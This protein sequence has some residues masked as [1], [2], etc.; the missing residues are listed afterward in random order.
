VNVV[1]C[2]GEGSGLLCEGYVLVQRY[3]VDEVPEGTLAEAAS[4]GVKD[5]ANGHEPGPLT[6]AIPG[7]AFDVVCDAM[8]IE[9]ASTIEADEAALAGMIAA[10]DSN[11]AYL[12]PQALRIIEEDQSGQIEGIGALVASEDLTAEDPETAPC[13]IISDTCRLVVVSTMTGGPAR[14]TGLLPGD[15]FVGVDGASI[16]GWSVDEVTAAVRG[17]AGT[18]VML[19]IERE[20][21]IL[22]ITITRAALVIPVVEA[23]V[24]NGVGYLRL[25]LFTDS[26]DRQVRQALSELLS[27]GVGHLV[28]DL[29]DNP[30]GALDATVNIA[31]EF[32]SGGV[33]VRTE[34]PD[35]V[36]TYEVEQGGVAT[37]EDLEVA[38]LVNRG[39]ASA[40]EVLSAALQERHRAVIIGENTFGKNTVQ[41]RFSLSNGGALKLTVARWVTAEGSDFGNGGVTPD[42]TAEFD[43]DLSVGEVVA[44]VS[45]LAGW[46]SAA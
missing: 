17:P 23:E 25:N 16:G 3:Y 6:C 33:V 12:N 41:Q 37:S 27:G 38:I 46:S 24:V 5:L 4:Q 43:P 13:A 45:G 34:A 10:L 2:D 35:E 40:S 7:P 28:L 42:I 44:E 8:A 9:G 29:R 18:E 20:G 14:L 11:S 21:E 15:V 32:L 19:S 36:I 31:S 39:S 22:D 1:L 30:G 26:A